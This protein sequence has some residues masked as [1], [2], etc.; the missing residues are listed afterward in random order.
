M[1]AGGVTEPPAPGPLRPPVAVLLSRFPRVTETFILREVAE[2]ERQ[3]QP[4][5]LVPLIRE[6]PPLV[7][8][9]A[10]PWVARALFTP[11]LSPSIVA[12]NLRALLRRPGAWIGTLARLGAGM[13]RSPGFLARTLV[14]FP[15][16]VYLAE[17]LAAEEV[18]HVHAHFA[19]HPATVAWVLERLAG[20]PYS[21]TVHAHDLFVDRTF[22]GAK[23]ARARF[24]RAISR[25]NRDYL[26]ERHPEAAGRIEMVH[27]GVEPERYDAGSEA[28][29]PGGGEHLRLLTVAALEPYKGVDR[30]VEAAAL[31][32]DRLAASGG[33]RL[34]WEVVGEGRLRP[35]LEAA[36]AGRGLGATVRLVGALPQDEVARRLAAADLFV[37]PSVVAPDGQMEGI[38]VALMEAMAAGRPVIASRLSGVPELVE[39]GV[40]GLLVPP[41]DVGA[42][43]AAVG[44]LAGDPP[45]A[46]RLAREGRA[47]VLREFRLEVTVAELRALLDRETGGGA[48]AQVGWWARPALAAAG[49]A[50]RPVGL[51][52]LRASPDSHVAELLVGCCRRG[53]D[54]LEVVV[55]RH[56]SRLGESAPPAERAR[57]EL[58]LLSR[59]SASGR[60]GPYGVPRPLLATPAGPDGTAV[61]LERALGERLDEIVRA[62]RFR[63]GAASRCELE[64]AFRR[65]GGWLRWFR[66][67]A[68]DGWSH[69]DF[70][71]GNVFV[72][73]ERVEV[74]DLE[75]ASPGTSGHRDLE[76][77][78]AYF[79]RHARRYFRFPGLGG[80]FRRLERAFR[81]GLEGPEGGSP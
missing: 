56:R 30:L 17:R 10:Q 34:A 22:L 77:D 29:T 40:S 44:R 46:A 6:R 54:P 37:L 1:S 60:G 13:L 48:A 51:R 73:K 19:T 16:A 8:P 5:V 12:A 42:L 25:F 18:A 50:D 28:P 4:V 62:R 32:R 80:R 65:A 66:E 36:V 64:D 24:V 9:E 35:G 63:P 49:L 27:V 81:A 58:A 55:K 14:L 61:V 75:G 52:R 33:P 78:A 3:G 41:G 45:L 67:R 79:L 74:V 31:L 68:G 76:D 59:L 72:T 47:R 38:P 26:A 11:W 69:G 20:I 23:L 70:W 71:P 43:A 15:K 57:R 7:H 53:S 21:V 2:L 39:D